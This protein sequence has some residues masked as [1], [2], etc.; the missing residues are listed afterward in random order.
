MDAL[1]A[2]RDFYESNI[3]KNYLFRPYVNQEV[4][5]LL[6]VINELWEHTKETRKVPEDKVKEALKRAIALTTRPKPKGT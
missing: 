2:A 6:D 4:E 5:F 3:D 1:S